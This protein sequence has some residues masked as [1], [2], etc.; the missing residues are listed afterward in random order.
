M[1]GGC[2][3]EDNIFKP[4]LKKISEKNTFKNELW[5]EP[6]FVFIVAKTR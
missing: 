2:V 4:I 6:L 3:N 5:I 1:F